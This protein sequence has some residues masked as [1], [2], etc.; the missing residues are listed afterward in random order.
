[1]GV[2]VGH[3][4]PNFEDTDIIDSEG[5]VELFG[6]L[7]I[8]VTDEHLGLSGVPCDD[9]RDVL[10][11]LGDP[12]LGGVCGDAGKVNAA[13]AD[14]DEKEQEEVSESSHGPD[15]GLQEVTSPEGFLVTLDKGGPGADAADGSGIDVMLL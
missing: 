1:M 2:L 5:I 14:M 11:L 7:A 3:F 15:F 4:G 13:G 8:Q 9:G 10:T 12:G 6:E